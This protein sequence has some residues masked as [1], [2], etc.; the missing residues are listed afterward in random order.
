MAAR[1]KDTT[2]T[3]TAAPK[4]RKKQSPYRM[5]QRVGSI[6]S[7]EDAF[8][9]LESLG[10]EMREGYD[11]MQ[12]YPGLAST[13]KCEAYGTAADTLEGLREFDIPEWM[14]DI[15][16][17]YTEAVKRR[18]AASRAVRCSNAINVLQAASMTIAELEEDAD[19]NPLTEDQK[20]EAESL[21]SD[22]DDMANEAENVE[23]P[24]LY[25]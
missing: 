14:R 10:E 22:I 15:D 20:A 19:G 21:A 16:I 7:I 11:N 18:G 1:K 8:S 4:K 3:D 13:S 24:G 12:Q 5:E 6:A 25:G 23:F 17:H 2:S 9:E